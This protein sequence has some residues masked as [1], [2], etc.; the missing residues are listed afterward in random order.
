MESDGVIPVS[1]SR[2]PDDGT[3]REILAGLLDFLRATVVNKVAGLSDE[4][5]FSSPVPPSTL[6]PAGVVKHLTGVE[7]FWFSIDFANADLVWPWTDDDPH[8]NFLLA[9]SDTLALIVA[10]YQAACERSRGVVAGAGLD[11]R[12]K[13]PEMSF[14]LR[15]ALAHMIEE[16]AR[17]CGHLDLLRERIDGATGQ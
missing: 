9:P 8:G 4:Q 1:R 12:A 2:P 3:E 6:S 14:T 15:Y 13:A 16:T 10:D 5:G 7:L 17:H 11:D